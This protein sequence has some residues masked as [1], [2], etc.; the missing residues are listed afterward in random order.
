MK[1]APTLACDRGQRRQAVVAALLADVVHGRVRAG[2]RLVTD[3]LAVRF[4]TSHTPIREA[5]IALSGIGLVDLAPNRGAVVRHVTRRDVREI[6]QVRRALECEAVR[7]ACGRIAL[8]DLDNLADD[9]RRLMAGEFSSTAAF[10]REARRVDSRLHDLVAASC[11][12][13]FLAAELTRLKTLFRAFRDVSYAQDAARNDVRRLAEEAGE[14]LAIV[15]ALRSGA[16]PEAARAMS[17][18][19]RGGGRYWGRGLPESENGSP[20]RPRRRTKQSN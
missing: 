3:K 15:D 13:R 1:K 14:H 4:G 9:L 18:H 17:R 10:V 2:Q 20:A 12:N 11:G 5:L 8:A 6:L 19:I 16:R 7:S